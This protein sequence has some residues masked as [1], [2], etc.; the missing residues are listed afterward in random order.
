[1]AA[2]K[3]SRKASDLAPRAIKSKDAGAVR[4][5]STITGNQASVK[6]I[7]WIAPPEPD[8]SQRANKV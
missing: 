7:S 2:K 6:T 3:K 4:G 5:G 1:M 8:R